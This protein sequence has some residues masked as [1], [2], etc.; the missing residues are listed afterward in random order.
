MTLGAQDPA[1][2]D[3]ALVGDVTSAFV[4]R[5]LFSGLV[6]LDNDLEVQPDLAESWEISDDR[7]IYT[8]MLRPNAR[9]ADGSPVT[10]E[11]VR[12]SLERATNPDLGRFLPAQT[13]LTDIVGVSEKLAG[14]ADEI[15]GIEVIDER[16][17][18]ITI[19]QPKSY[20]LSK[21][22]HP[23]SFVVD[24]EAVERGGAA[25]TE[26]PNG[27]G[28]FLIE[29]WQH[30]QSLVIQRNLNFYRDM[31]KLDRVTFLIGALANNPM[32][33][34]EQGEIDITSVPAYALDRVQDESNPLAPELVSVPQ[35]S[36]TFVG[37]NVTMPPFDDP[38]VRQ[39]FNLM[40]DR[41]RIAE[42]TLSGSVAPARGILPPGMP[43][44]NESLPPLRANLLEAA[45]LL[46]ESSYG[47]GAALPT[48]AAY[49]SGW[50]NMLDDIASEEFGIDIEVRDYE[51]FGDF[52]NA[53]DENEFPMFSFGWV[54]DYPDP[55]NFLDV[56]FRTGSG[57]NHTGYSNPEVDSLL[58]LAAVET[59]EEAR[60]ALYR[61]AEQ[62]ILE[63]VP[64]ILIY[65]DVEHTLIKPYVRGLEVTPLGILDLS[66]VE[67][68]RG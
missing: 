2:L 67:L 48:I 25:W 60:W 23:T 47:S 13:Y 6:R 33:L 29:T 51:N 1:S 38:Q 68:V 54:A 24:R 62:L 36:L 27:S 43:G 46:E 3:P 16:T 61:E 58:D 7:R 31:A 21:L 55:E 37:L 44:Y 66:T 5:Q 28:P 40:L 9:F 65:H 35:L 32:V 50:T 63:D 18:E 19:D 39:A 41:E 22:A 57:E 53:L 15:S 52:L 64:V 56:L 20:F 11:D 12:Y 49:G 8:F 59:D 42:V 4:V 26:Q 30:N 14:R 10:A 34:Y 17:I 45:D